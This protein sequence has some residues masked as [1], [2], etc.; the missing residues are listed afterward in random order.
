MGGAPPPPLGS[1]PQ[2]A[3]GAHFFDPLGSRGGVPEDQPARGVGEAPHHFQQFLAGARV[4]ER[5][6]SGVPSQ[7]RP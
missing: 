5:G 2:G 7:G 1:A 6:S 3:P 4:W